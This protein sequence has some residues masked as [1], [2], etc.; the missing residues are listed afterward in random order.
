MQL[1]NGKTFPLRY[2]TASDG[3]AGANVCSANLPPVGSVM[4]KK[5]F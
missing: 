1:F 4:K 2:A 5:W 3:Y